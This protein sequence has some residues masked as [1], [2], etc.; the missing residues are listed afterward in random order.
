MKKLLVIGSINND[1]IINCDRRPQAGETLMG[2]S[3]SYLPGG[4]G[5]NQA[6]AAARMGA[7]VTFMGCV[8]DDSFGQD[9]I[10]NLND[11]NVATD[12]VKVIENEQTGVACITVANGDNSILVVEGANQHTDISMIE[13][14]AD[15]IKQFEYILIQNEIPVE[16]VEYLIEFCTQNNLKTIYNP[17]PFKKLADT[18]LDK[19]FLITPNEHEVKEM[20]YQQFADNLI[21]TRGKEG[22]E[23]Q[24]K[25]YPTVEL[26]AV[27]TTGAGDT[28]NG[29]LCALLI[30]GYSIA[31]AI[32]IAQKAC[33]KSIMQVGAQAA[34]PYRKDLI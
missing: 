14:Y 29:A 20:G 24:S 8:G 2:N 10:K 26:E 19:L 25:I 7:D 22:V 13:Q 34:M 1:F 18:N 30:E 6:V 11:N 17:A 3:I 15:E 32:E 33:Q 31:D 9:M 28:F 23:Y 16:T 27:D 4:K 21:I 5:A 12:F